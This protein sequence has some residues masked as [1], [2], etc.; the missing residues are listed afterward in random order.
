MEKKLAWKS[1]K[2]QVMPALTV[3]ISC[4]EIVHHSLQLLVWGSSEIDK[5]ASYILEAKI[6]LWKLL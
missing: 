1:D 2:D 3:D 4:Q 5:V 6:P